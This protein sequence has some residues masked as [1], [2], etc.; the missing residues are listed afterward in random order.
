MQVTRTPLLRAGSLLGKVLAAGLLIALFQP[1]SLAKKKN[2]RAE[3]LRSLE[4]IYVDGTGLAAEY[5]RRN[6]EQQ[7]CLKHVS[8]E[9]LADARLEIWENIGPCPMNLTGVCRGI[10]ARLID[11]ES[12]KALWY[13][14]DDEIAGAT[15]LT[16]SQTAGKWVLWNLNSAC[17]K[18]R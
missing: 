11:R 12:A 6:L 14:S 7:T 16:G 8:E 15:S 4:S 13:R 3:R 5:I 1:F 2:K 18:G 17:C 10:S 9:D